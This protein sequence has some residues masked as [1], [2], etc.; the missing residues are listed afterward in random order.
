MGGL[1]ENGSSGLAEL[2]KRLACR[3]GSYEAWLATVA[4]NSAISYVRAHAEYLGH[5]EREGGRWAIH[6]PV[7]EAMVDGGL[8][9][10]RLA[11][12]RRILAF[13]EERLRPEQ[14]GALVEWMQ[15]G[16][17]GGIAEDLEMGSN[18]AATRLG[19]SALRRLRFQFA[20]GEKKRHE[21]QKNS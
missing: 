11:E 18:D 9:P 10:A 15:T 19:R 12:A 14:R 4:R 5:V 7:S 20:T 6:L 17:H 8:D 16:D 3:D 1:R 21:V 13:A 2:G